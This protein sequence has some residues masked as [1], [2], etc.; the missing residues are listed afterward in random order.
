MQCSHGNLAQHFNQS[1]QTNLN[2]HATFFPRFLVL[3][4]LAEA[5]LFGTWLIS[6]QGVKS[7]QSFLSVR[8]MCTSNPSRMQQNT[9]KKV[10]F[11]LK[12]T[13]KEDMSQWKKDEEM[14]T[15]YNNNTFVKLY[16]CRNRN[17]EILKRKSCFI[18]FHKFL[19]KCTT[20]SYMS[21]YAKCSLVKEG[22]AL[23]PER[24]S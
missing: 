7:F 19:D 9:P 5:I 21:V 2:L 12:W 23:R 22:N 20:M 24:L 11:P 16:K 8:L 15:R 1:S 14:L 6:E 3:L 13:K 10:C 17:N 18:I 4:R